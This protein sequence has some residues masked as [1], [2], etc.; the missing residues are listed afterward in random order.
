MVIQMVIH[1]FY[2]PGGHFS[3]CTYTFYTTVFTI[4]NLPPIRFRA[5][6]AK[7]ITAQLVTCLTR[8]RDQTIWREIQNRE[9]VY[10]LYDIYFLHYSVELGKQLAKVIQ[11]DLKGSSPVSNHDSSTNALINF[12]KQTK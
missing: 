12:I 4:L 10:I 8:K 11:S 7:K 2:N 5:R 6:P 1:S 9:K 3:P